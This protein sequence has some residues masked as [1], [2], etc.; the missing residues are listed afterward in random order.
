MDIHSATFPD[1]GKRKQR[2]EKGGGGMVGVMQ[3]KEIPFS[4]LHKMVKLLISTVALEQLNVLEYQ[5]MLQW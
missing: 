5:Q 1:K 3:Q 4:N 2:P